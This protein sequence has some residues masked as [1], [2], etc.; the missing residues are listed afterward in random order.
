MK[1]KVILVTSTLFLTFWWLSCI[2]FLTLPILLHSGTAGIVGRLFIACIAIFFIWLAVKIIQRK[3]YAWFLGAFLYGI[4][5]LF[6]LLSFLGLAMLV[7]SALGTD[8]H[9]ITLIRFAGP[10]GFA[11]LTVC[12]FTSLYFYK[13]VRFLGR[14]S[15]MKRLK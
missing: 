9:D 6:S 10:L 7:F 11:I 12:A 13:D 3:R 15:M 2:C 8:S 14:F 4:S 1:A 5:C